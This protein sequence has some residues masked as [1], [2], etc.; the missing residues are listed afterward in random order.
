VRRIVKTMYNWLLLA[1]SGLLMCI[2]HTGADSDI[3]LHDTTEYPLLSCLYLFKCT[4]C[5]V[6]KCYILA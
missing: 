1:L 3:N 5:L 6:Q 2:I 4:A